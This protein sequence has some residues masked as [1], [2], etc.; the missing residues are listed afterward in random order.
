LTLR[1]TAAGLEGVGVRLDTLVNGNARNPSSRD[2]MGPHIRRQ[3][4]SVS[5]KRY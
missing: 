4:Q 5:H 3:A 1:H 2:G